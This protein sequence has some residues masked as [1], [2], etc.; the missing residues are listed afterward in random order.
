M[1]QAPSGQRVNT[2]SCVFGAVIG[3]SASPRRILDIGTGTGVLA[4]MMAAR[5]SHAK[6]TAVEPETSIAEVAR[7]NFLKSQWSNR[8][9]VLVSRAQELEPSMLGTFDFVVCNPPYF[10][11]SMISDDRLRMVA[12]HNTDL[13]PAELYDAMKRMMTNEGSMWLSFPEDSK[14]L[15][16]S[17]GFD[18]DLHL[19]HQIMVM[20]HPDAKPHMAVAGWS[21]SKPE[22]M[23]E[24]VIYYRD[25]HKGMASPWM[26]T[27]REDW[28]PSSYNAQFY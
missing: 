6:I 1:L 4:L 26:R 9:E 21:R 28:F 11:N 12:R 15:W 22:S 8:I 27:F 3:P 18:A 13:S 14:D 20:D 10:Q 17:P 25:S 19:T 5:F 2:D 7:D 23:I 16:L 24:N